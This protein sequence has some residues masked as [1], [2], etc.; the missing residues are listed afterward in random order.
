M[1]SGRGQVAWH[2]GLVILQW[3]YSVPQRLDGFMC[4]LNYPRACVPCC[5]PLSRLSEL[6]R[7]V[8]FKQTLIALAAVLAYFSLFAR[9]IAV[10]TF[11]DAK[12]ALASTSLFWLRS[13]LPSQD[14]VFWMAYYEKI[15][16]DCGTQ[17]YHL[18]FASL[19][20]PCLQCLL[21][22]RELMWRPLLITTLCLGSKLGQRTFS[23][24][25]P[26]VLALLW[27]ASRFASRDPPSGRL[28]SITRHESWF[29]ILKHTTRR[30]ARVLNI[31]KIATPSLEFGV[32]RGDS[33]VCV[34]FASWPFIESWNLGLLC[35][36]KY[37]SD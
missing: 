34:S 30:F 9:I 19:I 3:G 31:P 13:S 16:F 25:D 35:A 2:I 14:S 33:S 37:R 32:W 12:K 20:R 24:I 29:P 10:P 22:P 18:K 36:R 6:P 23:L 27:R 5:H 7:I 21:Y 26:M 8:M 15:C 1:L 11:S 17:Q 28:W 4:H